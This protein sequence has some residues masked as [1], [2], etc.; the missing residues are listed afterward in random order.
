M[1]SARLCPRMSH[2]RSLRFLSSSGRSFYDD[3]GLSKTA[4]VEDIKKAYRKLALKWH[5]D[6][7]PNNAEAEKQFKKV[8]EAYAVLSD[9]SKRAEY[10]AQSSNPFSAQGPNPFTHQPSHGQYRAQGFS[11]PQ[12]E[13]VFREF[14]GN[15]KDLFREM[16][17]LLHN[18]RHNP[19]VRPTGHGQTAGLSQEQI[20]QLFGRKPP[21]HMQFSQQVSV[22][23]D[24]RRVVMNVSH[25]SSTSGSDCR[26]GRG[27]LR[28]RMGEAPSSQKTFADT[29]VEELLRS[30]G[31]TKSSPTPPTPAPEQPILPLVAKEAG[32]LLWAAVKHWLKAMV[33]KVRR[34]FHL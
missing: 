3:L 10:D 34:L 19:N 5:P 4:T 25:Q 13:Q 27:R 28:S 17:S 33:L 6:R 12:A 11:G 30:S 7:N 22:A 16:E 26:R 9:P 20:N 18:M 14:F 8:S 29:I 1:F 32:K 24:G 21:I 15:N 23:P 2:L 31:A